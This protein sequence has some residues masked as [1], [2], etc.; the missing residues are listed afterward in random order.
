M[1]C[2]V[3]N[4]NYERVMAVMDKFLKERYKNVVP[5]HAA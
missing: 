2:N 1:N 5:V 3:R 4:A